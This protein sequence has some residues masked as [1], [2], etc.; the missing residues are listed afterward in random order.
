MPEAFLKGLQ[1]PEYVHVL[2]NPFPV[3]GLVMGFVALVV[4]LILCSRHARLLALFLIFL[5]ALSAWP[6][7]RYGLRGY[8]RVKAMSDSEGLMW[9]DEHKARAE[10]LIFVFYTLAVLALTGMGAEWN[11]SRAALPLSILILVLTVSAL[12]AGAY[13]SYSGGHIRHREFR[14]EPPP[15]QPASRFNPL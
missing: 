4:A 5:S 3:Y 13:I 15:E 11:R 10:R 9:L 14:F 7:F 2:F 1:Q 6:T 8:D 12:V